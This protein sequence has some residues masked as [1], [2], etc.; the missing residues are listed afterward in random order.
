[1]GVR[2]TSDKRGN[3][4]PLEMKE[5]LTELRR[6]EAKYSA[7]T[8]GEIYRDIISARYERA[9]GEKPTPEQLTDYIYGVARWEEELFAGVE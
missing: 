8:K 5:K 4:Y 2:F 7:K 1:M 3:I 6:T 9:N